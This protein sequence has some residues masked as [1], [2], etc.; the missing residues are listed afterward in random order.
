MGFYM[1][2]KL[3]ILIRILRT[4]DNTHFASCGGDKSVFL[5]DVQAGAVVRRFS[6]HNSKVNTVAFNHDGSVL[7][8][9]E[10]IKCLRQCLLRRLQ[11]HTIQ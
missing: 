10:S 9:G 11:V 6:G 7:A 3:V 8:S 4:Q 2:N 5:W 1:I